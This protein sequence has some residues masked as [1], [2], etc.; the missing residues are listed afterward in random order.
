M[1]LAD[2]II[3]AVGKMVRVV[4]EPKNDAIK[5][6]SPLPP[7]NYNA[8]ICKGQKYF[9]MRRV[10]VTSYGPVSDPSVTAQCR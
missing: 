3:C 7:P 2:V 1:L 9:L 4:N 5:A 8:S 6:N 10:V